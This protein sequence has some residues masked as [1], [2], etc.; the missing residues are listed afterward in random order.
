MIQ[1][2]GCKCLIN[3]RHA[4]TMS[5]SRHKDSEYCHNMNTA[6]FRVVHLSA[7]SPLRVGIRILT[8]LTEELRLFQWI[9]EEVP[10]LSTAAVRY[11]AYSSRKSSTTTQ[12]LPRSSIDLFASDLA[13][14]KLTIAIV[15]RARTVAT[16]PTTHTHCQFSLLSH[17]ALCHN[18]YPALP[19]T[20]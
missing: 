17:T 20:L 12:Q 18:G 7:V 13:S 14:N 3:K 19:S 10:A 6:P 8:I 1:V 15:V 4:L 2:R 11:R 5:Q 16:T 9:T